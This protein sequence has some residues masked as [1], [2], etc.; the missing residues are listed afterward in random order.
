MSFCCGLFHDADGIH[1]YI[2]S[3]HFQIHDIEQEFKQLDHFQSRIK[4][5]S[6]E[7]MPKISEEYSTFLEAFKGQINRFVGDM[8]S[9]YL[10]KVQVHY[11][12]IAKYLTM[13]MA[14]VMSKTARI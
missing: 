11:P 2:N 7:A 13:Y 14:K 4:K 10:G 9:P 12:E 6:S 5:G 3:L 8:N 1:N